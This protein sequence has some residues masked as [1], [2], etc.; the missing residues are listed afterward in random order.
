MFKTGLLCRGVSDNHML[1]NLCTLKALSKDDAILDDL[2][3][4]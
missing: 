2:T 1:R 3:N 4:P